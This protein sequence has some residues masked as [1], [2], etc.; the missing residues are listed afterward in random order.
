MAP[1]HGIL[2]CTKWCYQVLT[3]LHLNTLSGCQ[4][5]WTSIINQCHTIKVRKVPVLLTSIQTPDFTNDIIHHSAFTNHLARYSSP[6]MYYN[7]LDKWFFWSH[8][9]ENPRRDF[10]F[11][12]V[13]CVL[14]VFE[15]KGLHMGQVDSIQSYNYKLCMVIK[16]RY[17]LTL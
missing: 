17:F 12:F 10:S 3:A 6:T 11:V 15:E 8:K 1:K 13:L 16:M 4:N 5:S 2:L 9:E 14:C 7:H